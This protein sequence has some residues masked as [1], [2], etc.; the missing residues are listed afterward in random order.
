MHLVDPKVVQ[1]G[2]A[3]TLSVQRTIPTR[4]AHRIGAWVFVDHYSVDDADAAEA[5]NVGAHPHTGLQT[6]SWVFAGLIEHR[7]SGG[8][9]GFI[10]PGELNLMTAGRGIAHSEYSMPVE[11]MLQGVQLWI[12]LPDHARLIEPDF[13]HYVPEPVLGDRFIARVFLGSLLGS[14]SPVQT[15]TPLLGAQLDLDAPASLTID[16]DPA[17]EHGLL[18]DRGSVRVS[19][20]ESELTAAEGQL[21]VLPRGLRELTVATDTGARLVLLGGEPFE[22]PIVMWWNF[23]GRTHEE[24]VSWREQWAAELTGTAATR[25][26]GLPVDD[27]GVAEPVPDAP[28]LSMRL[29]ARG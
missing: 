21:L 20:G 26:F 19:D 24:I 1:L 5:M 12:A 10:K 9:H 7:D 22:E 23:I 3:G 6:A 16:I 13:T 8:V 15:Y 17:F 11:A 18:V 2:A 28:P 4:G 25:M 14:T 29:K 27:V